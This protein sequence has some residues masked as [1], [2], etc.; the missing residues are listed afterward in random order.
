MRLDVL[1]HGHGRAARVF[2]RVVATVLRNEVDDVVKTALHRPDFFGRQ[3]LAFGTAVLRGPSFWTPAE[4]EH[5][6]VVVSQLNTCP[7]CVRVHT[8]TTRIESRG[9]VALGTGDV[10]PELAATL[11]FLEKVTRTP[12][13]VT[14]ADAD[15]VRAAGVPD[16]AIADALD[17]GLMFDTVNRLANAFDWGWDSEGHVG[18]AARVIHW[19][20]YRLPGF[21]LR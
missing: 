21:V 13:E 10:R 15:A 8:E 19:T 4:R 20:S 18:A 1:E 11:A 3:L 5:M 7:F 14:P 9:E 2:Q 6:A 12:D 17:V 16:A